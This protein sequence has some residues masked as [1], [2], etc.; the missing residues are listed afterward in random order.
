LLRYAD[1]WE[2]VSI[3]ESDFLNYLQQHRQT[4][5]PIE[6]VWSDGS[7]DRIGIIRNSSK[8]GRD[9]IGFKLD[10]M[11]PS[12]R[13]GYKKMDIAHAKRPGTYAIRYYKD[14]YAMQTTTIVLDHSRAFN[15]FV[16]EG[17]EGYDMTFI[18]ISTPMPTNH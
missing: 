5:D 2:T 17:D 12:W 11:L 8:P 13:K 16:Q 3:S 6:G 10:V 7:P 1:K 9:F 4:L 15:F 18:K 14:D